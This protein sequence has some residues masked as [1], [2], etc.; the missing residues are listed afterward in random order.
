MEQKR[1]KM[2]T[3]NACSQ[4]SDHTPSIQ[5]AVQ[6][7]TQNMNTLSPKIKE[8]TQLTSS[9]HSADFDTPALLMTENVPGNSSSS[10][11]YAVSRKPSEIP[12]AHPQYYFRTDVHNIRTL[13]K[14]LLFHLQPG[15]ERTYYIHQSK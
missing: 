6:M 9:V 13:P 10:Q 8:R 5:K 15:N 14:D 2:T 12:T 1:Q 11:A 7:V 4:R 3:P